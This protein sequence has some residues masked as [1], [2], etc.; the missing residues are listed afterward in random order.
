MSVVPGC[1]LGMSNLSGKDCNSHVAESGFGPESIKPTLFCTMQVFESRPLILQRSAEARVGPL[2][3]FI[4]AT[5]LSA[6]NAPWELGTG[7]LTD[8]NETQSLPPGVAVEGDWA[9]FRRVLQTTG[10]QGP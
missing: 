10:S 5:L 7:G 6:C 3:Y 2:L 8:G 9:M 1:S 4:L